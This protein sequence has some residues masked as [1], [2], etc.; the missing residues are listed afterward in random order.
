MGGYIGSK[1]SVT[2]VDGYTRAEADQAIADAAFDP[3]TLATVATTG[4]YT[5]LSNVPA[6]IVVDASYVHT[7]N[8]YTTTEKSKLAG[9]EAGATADQTKADIDALGIAASTAATLATARNI[10]LT[11]DVTG[12]ANFNGSENINI[13]A[14]VADDSHNH[15]NYLNRSAS[16]ETDLDTKYDADMFGWSPSTVGRPESYGQGISIVSNGNTHNNSSNW[17]T[18]LGFG[19]AGDTAY[20]RTKVNS[21]G[22]GPWQ[23][24]WHS[25]NDGAG[26]GLDADLLDGLHVHDGRNYE[27]NKIVRTD[28]SGY[29]QAGWINTPSGQTNAT[30]YKIYASNDD[31]LRYVTPAHLIGQLG[32]NTSF[33]AV[34]TYM[35]ANNN[36]GGAYNPG[37]TVAGSS[38]RPTTAGNPSYTAYVPSGTWMLMGYKTGTNTVWSGTYETSLWLRIS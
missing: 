11:G 15:S 37:S 9:I 19:T 14:T 12:S 31:Y 4:S 28:G 5:D 36:S 30:I 8:N 32:A 3:N 24:I 38:L 23:T 21:G 33:G 25:G 2:Q 27:A 1:S 6:N 16:I 22:W 17:I 35:F 34:G 20:F 18:Q 13:T 26:S 7:D 29:I 10:A